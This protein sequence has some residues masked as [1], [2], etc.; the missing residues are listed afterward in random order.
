MFRDESMKLPLQRNSFHRSVPVS[1]FSVRHSFRQ[2]NDVEPTACVRSK[3]A[4]LRAHS[5]QRWVGQ[6]TTEIG[7]PAM[8]SNFNFRVKREIRYRVVQRN[9]IRKFHT[10][11]SNDLKWLFGIH[12][13]NNNAE[14][15][16][17]AR[18]RKYHPFWPRVMYSQHT[19][20]TH[21]EN[22]LVCVYLKCVIS[23]S[24]EYVS[25][26]R[27]RKKILRKQKYVNFVI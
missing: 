7:F 16:Y 6:Q 12:N 11:K 1:F 23:H 20:I 18:M 17:R 9:F 26:P 22:V 15:C 24:L 5:N 13:H 19:I 21:W 10:N 3:I 14:D 2:L 25:R 27:G 4:R 8:R